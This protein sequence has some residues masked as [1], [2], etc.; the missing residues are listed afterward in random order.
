MSEGESDFALRVH[1]LLKRVEWDGFVT[2]ADSDD[3]HDTQCPACGAPS[4]HKMEMSRH[5][6]DCELKKLIE[7]SARRMTS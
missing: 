2:E 6:H 3:Y 1:R 5:E 4:F 7:E